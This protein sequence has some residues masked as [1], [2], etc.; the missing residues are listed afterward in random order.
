MK[1][2]LCVF[3]SDVPVVMIMKDGKY[4]AHFG[5]SELFVEV[6]GDEADNDP[7]EDPEDENE[8]LSHDFIRK[9]RKGAIAQSHNIGQITYYATETCA[10]QHRT[11]CF[12]ISICGTKT[13]LFRWDRAGVIV[14]GAFDLHA[15]PELLCRFLWRYSHATD[16]QRGFDMTVTKAT[17]EE[18]LK[19]VEVVTE[20]IKDQLSPA[21]DELTGLLEKHYE[22][23][24]VFKIPIVPQ[25]PPEN[26]SQPRLGQGDHDGMEPMSLPYP[27][28]EVWQE[29]NTVV[30]DDDT[31]APPASTNASSTISED[32][33]DDGISMHPTSR[34]R[35]YRQVQHFLVS[36]PVSAPLTVATRG[37]RGYW[38]VKIPDEGL[39]EKKHVIAFLKDTWRVNVAAMEIEGEVMAML[40]EAGVKFVSDI[41]CQGDVPGKMSGYYPRKDN[42]SKRLRSNAKS[43]AY[44][45]TSDQSTLTD[46][47]ANEEWNCN[48]DEKSTI[49]RSTPHVHYRM[50][51]I[52]VGYPLSSF[53]GTK[54]LIH[55]GR[56]GYLGK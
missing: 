3:S 21:A 33:A 12:S 47:F 14:S 56:C 13:R 17:R 20:H 27:W 46:R 8:S 37:T 35:K 10:R 23:N 11:H 19:F 30:G 38:A 25:Q 18:E 40:V 44:H 51:S 52:E 24:A 16:A 7:F 4:I 39:N 22:P 42:I 15:N 34:C 31:P 1:P 48:R 50:A 43:V 55:G 29:E 53:R 9:D 26:K 2:D 41:F 45:Q 28:E 49:A 32:I 36:I 5:F 54:D 6:K